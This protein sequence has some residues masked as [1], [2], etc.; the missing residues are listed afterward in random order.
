MEEE[1]MRGVM[2]EEERRKM[3]GEF[4]QMTIRPRF[5]EKGGIE[6]KTKA[7]VAKMNKLE[8]NEY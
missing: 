4:R 6:K 2:E 7:L 5:R 3:V 8:I 1:V